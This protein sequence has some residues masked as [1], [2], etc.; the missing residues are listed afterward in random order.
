MKHGKL[1][2]ELTQVLS[3]HGCFQSYLHKMAR[4]EDDLFT[5]WERVDS[6]ERLF[7]HCSK[8]DELR[9]QAGNVEVKP[10]TLVGY[11]IGS[12]ENGKPLL[13]PSCR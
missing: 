7:F 6:A 12:Q 8:C 1:S 2:F 4:A 13:R 10:E 3:G 9:Q 11:I 5:E